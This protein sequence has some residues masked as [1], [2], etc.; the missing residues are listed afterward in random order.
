[1]AEIAEVLGSGTRSS[2]KGA[3]VKESDAIGRFGPALGSVSAGPRPAWVARSPV[4]IGAHALAREA[5]G[6]ERR[7]TDRATFLSHV[8]EVGALLYRAGFDDRLVAAG[9]LH[10]SVERGTLTAGRLRAEV[11][12][13]VCALVLALTEDA[14]ISSFALRKKALRGQVRAAGNRAVTVFAAD[15]LSD[16][17]G[18]R[19]GIRA[20]RRGVESRMG[21][22]VEAM[23]YHYR[24]SVQMIEASDPGSAFIT[25]LRTELDGLGP[26]PRFS[27]QTPPRATS[28]P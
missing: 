6:F 9:L 27:A 10:D 23:A 25:A 21:T 14:K 2:L 16:I 5:H 13:E 19:R 4:L 15:K 22:T 17:R 28:R 20:G 26:R 3:G 8:V 7:A 11:D 24:E 12:P 1:M 18:L